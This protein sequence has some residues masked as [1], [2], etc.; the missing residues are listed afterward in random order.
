MAEDDL[1]QFLEVGKPI[2]QA[3]AIDGQMGSLVSK[4]LPILAMGIE[5][6]HMAI[7]ALFENALD[8]QRE[9][10]RLP[11]SRRAQQREMLA[12]HVIDADPRRHL[13][14]VIE[15]SHNDFPPAGD[16]INV[17]G[18]GFARNT[19]DRFERRDV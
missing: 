12:Q 19:H 6:E 14:G 17:S 8:Y 5:Q 3:E 10:T 16:G 15:G 2:R 18:V 11:G 13:R 7:L 9:R 4:G 1:G